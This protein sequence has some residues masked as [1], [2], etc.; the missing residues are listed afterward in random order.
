M[1]C[2]LTFQCL[3][4]GSL[5]KQD[6]VCDLLERRFWKMG[7]ILETRG[8]MRRENIQEGFESKKT[9]L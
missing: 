7:K 8:W 6:R 3:I 2:H 5:K 1:V 4:I 9:Y